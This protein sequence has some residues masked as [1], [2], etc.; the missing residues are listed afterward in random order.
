MTLT[1]CPT[2]GIVGDEG[3]P[4]EPCRVMDAQ[5]AVRIAT[6]PT[7]AELA[8]WE[9]VVRS[10]A[11]LDIATD[12]CLIAEVQRLREA[13]RAVLNVRGEDFTHPVV[14]DASRP[15]LMICAMR[16]HARAALFPTPAEAT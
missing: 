14:T 12:L 10:D 11:Y 13:L 7:D 1:R 5:D 9:G 16:D 6:P 3:K 15:S 8:F 2:C 4:C